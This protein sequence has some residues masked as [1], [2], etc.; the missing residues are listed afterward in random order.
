MEEKAQIEAAV[1]AAQ[2]G[3][4][5]ILGSVQIDLIATPDGTAGVQASST[6]PSLFTALGLLE[7]GKDAL[8]QQAQQAQQPQ[9]RLVRAT[10]NV[11]RV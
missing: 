7:M 9:S 1:A 5:R 2:A 11:P 3:Q 6:M 10:G 8:K 4:P